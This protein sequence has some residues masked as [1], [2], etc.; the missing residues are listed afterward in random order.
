MF[1]SGTGAERYQPSVV[2]AYRPCDHALAAM[3][4]PYCEPGDAVPEILST[5]IVDGADELG[6]LVLRAGRDDV[7]WYGSTLDIHEARRL[8]PHANA[9]TLQVAAGVLGGLVW[10]LENR[11]RGLVSAEQTDHHRVLEIARPYLGELIGK[12]GIWSRKSAGWTTVK[13]LVSGSR[14]TD[15]AEKPGL[16]E[17]NRTAAPM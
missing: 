9:T 11:G 6:V 7:Y 5:E 12:R 16:I 3:A 13:L 10:V 4:D 1:T 15:K 2:F 17:V 14:E 8:I